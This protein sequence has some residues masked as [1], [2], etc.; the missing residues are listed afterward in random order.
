M[1]ISY[2]TSFEEPFALSAYDGK[3]IGGAAP[4][5]AHPATTGRFRTTVIRTGAPEQSRLKMS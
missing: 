4:K 2:S 1:Y 3:R 5:H